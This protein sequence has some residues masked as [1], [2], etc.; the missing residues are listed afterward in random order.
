[1]LRTTLLGTALALLLIAVS[2]GQARALSVDYG[3]LHGTKWWDLDGDGQRD[4]C[5]PGLEGWQI[6]LSD[7]A[8][9][10]ATITTDANGDYWFE[11]VPIG[12]WEVS[13]ILQPGW[14]Q[15][16]PSGDGSHQ[17]TLNPGEVVTGLDFGNKEVPE[18]SSLLLL[19]LGLLPLVRKR[20]T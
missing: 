5:E 7:G 12:D 13:E 19:G 11:M 8:G 9:V 4:C 15:T 3:E 10:V 14:V 2:T 18:P 1:M 17:V 20:Q 6:Q 16:F